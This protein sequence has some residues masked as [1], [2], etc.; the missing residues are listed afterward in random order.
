MARG[1][2]SA[3]TRHVL[4]I[5]LAA[6]VVLA[7][8]LL[9]Q[10]FL[11]YFGVT[12]PPFVILLPAVMI[13]A[14]FFGFWAGL[15]A[16]A[17]GAALAGIWIFPPTGKLKIEDPADAVTLVLFL[18]MGF[19]ICTIAEQYRRNQRRIAALEREEA[20][21]KTRTSLEAALSSMTDAVFISDALGNFVEFNDAFATFH[22]LASKEDCAR[23]L[24]DY[25]AFIELL[26]ANGEPVP[27]EMW[28]VPRALRGETAS[29]VEYTL[30]RKD[31]GETWVGSYNFSPIRDEDGAIVGAV[32]AARDITE[33]KRAE[34]ELRA[35]EMRYRTAFQTSFDAIFIARSR[36]EKYIEVNKAFLDVT[37]Y[38]REEVIERTSRE[39][40]L[41]T[42]RRDWEN[43]AAFLR[44][45]PIYRDLQTQFTKKSGEVFWGVMS[46]SAIMV[47]GELCFLCVLR[48]ISDAKLAEEE[49]RSLAFY[50]PLTKLP[51]RRQL[52]EQLRTSMTFSLE[53]GRKLALL[54]VDLDNFKI[55]NDTLGHHTG[56]QLL[57]DVAQRL[58]ECARK[59][60]TVG[61]LGGDEFVVLLE[62]LSE[63][64]EEAAAQAKVVAE[65][66]LARIEEPYQID[67]RETIST[68]SIGITVFGDNSGNINEVLQQ[69]DI[70]MYQA[71]AAGRNGISFFAPALQAAVNARAV[72]EEDLRQGIKLQQFLLYYQAQVEDG[73]VIGAE[74][75]LRW[76]HPRRGILFP[77]EFISL[78]EETRQILP[79]GNWAL[80]SACKQLAVWAGDKKTASIKVAV[81][82]SAMQWRQPDFVEAVLT[83]VKRTGA[84]PRNLQLEL[85]ESTLVENVEDMIAKMTALKSHGL[86]FSVDDFGTGYSSLAY[87][88][89]LPLDQLKIDRSFVRDLLVDASSASIAQAI[90]SLSHALGLSVIAE[91]V[92]SERQLEILADLGCHAYQGYLFS[93]PVPLPE[94]EKLL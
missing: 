14:L 80:E 84:N 13:D 93:R 44:Q 71:K 63:T 27:L 39:L 36:D 28:S 22:K 82:I 10:I 50:D 73:R 61:R 43:L 31:T 1:K 2:K 87:L 40:G 42:D 59:V 15:L 35:S 70:A 8:F 90:I 26:M 34:D 38:D 74:V 66:V 49:I 64:T 7:G 37:G 3:L 78:A 83:V 88:K 18:A 89:R 94:F 60:G 54:F 16:T 57:Q 68:C 91:G 81:N 29:N 45:R 56:D 11:L 17:L 69:A 12:L 6:L 75:L 72:L 65:K 52:Q 48:D 76:Q 79:L 41:W 67:G 86:S 47:E 62:D 85:T 30:R 4:R 46:A 77:G 20:L 9:R 5:A 55:V 53:S 51:N 21:R 19:L 32:V 24:E 58:I 92:E 25:P 33:E 23:N